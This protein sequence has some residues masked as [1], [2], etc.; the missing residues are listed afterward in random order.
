MTYGAVPM[1]RRPKKP[2]QVF[3]PGGQ[4][5][6][7]EYFCYRKEID[8]LSRAISDNKVPILSGKSGTG[9]TS[10]VEYFKAKVFKK[11]SLI[12]TVTNAHNIQSIRDKC[13][14]KYKGDSE[15]IAKT[16]GKKLGSKLKPLGRGPEV[17][18]EFSGRDI[19]ERIIKD[20]PVSEIAQ[21]LDNKLLVLDNIDRANEELRESMIDL[22]IL[23][24][25]NPKLALILAGI[26]AYTFLG[27][28]NPRKKRAHW[29]TYAK[30]RVHAINVGP[31]PLD[32]GQEIVSKGMKA[33]RLGHSQNLCRRIAQMGLGDNGLIHE[34][35]KAV[36][37]EA[38]SQG[39]PFISFQVFSEAMK[40]FEDY[41]KDEYCI[42]FERWEKSHNR[43][44]ESI[45]IV[46][47]FFYEMLRIGEI[48]RI[49]KSAF[50][51]DIENK[52]IVNY[53]NGFIKVEMIK[54]AGVKYELR[55]RKYKLYLRAIT[56]EEYSDAYE[57]L[58]EMTDL[59][60]DKD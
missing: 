9:K 58:S 37:E 29:E 32:S 33:L 57:L 38:F 12:V 7:P 59:V 2:Y 22:I 51:L 17:R 19:H 31:L 56:R 3:F 28:K 27:S 42:D 11:E 39:K 25:E 24:S 4:P 10:L 1:L 49:V 16:G 18:L 26:D 48:K 52:E 43:E 21:L 5:V 44:M 55:E 54:K 8:H 36:A 46:L 6:D 15:E 20:I 34:I 60:V 53:L 30:R 47:A 45:L 35:A 13:F 50:N 41:K 23:F 40:E 14:K